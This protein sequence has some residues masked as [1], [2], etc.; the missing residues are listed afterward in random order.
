MLS[1]KTTLLGAI[2]IMLTAIGPVLDH[3]FPIVGLSWV[4][5]CTSLAGLATGAGLLVAKDASAHSIPAQIEA[6]QAV[7]TAAT[8]EQAQEA[9]AQM[10][11]ADQEAAQK[12]KE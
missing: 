9:K 8:P 2:V 6:A 10:K 11:Q 12:P 3:Y 7:V 4:A 1:W 5:V